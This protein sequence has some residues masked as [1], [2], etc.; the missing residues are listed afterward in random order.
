MKRLIP[1]LFAA[2]ALGISLM[3][4]TQ[5]ATDRLDQPLS[6]A[7]S[8]STESLDNGL[9]EQLR[10]ARMQGSTSAIDKLIESIQQ[11][12][13]ASPQQKSLWHSL[14][15]SYLERALQRAHLRGMAPGQPTFSTL[16]NDFRKDLTLGLE[17]VEKAREYGDES[18]ELFRIEAALMSQH[19]TGVTTAIRW[20]RKITASLTQASNRIYGDPKL[21]VALGLRKLLA[22]TWFGNDPEKALEHFKIADKAEDDERPAIFAAMAS[23]LKEDTQQATRW[24][25]RALQINPQNK[26][27]RVVLKRL[28]KNEGEPFSRDVSE[29]EL[30]ALH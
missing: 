2:L 23:F 5:L 18:G 16:P 3:I 26:F 14:A 1:V 11:A 9:S 22:P 15:E 6:K 17:A 20:N 28:E 29:E 27:A 7:A 4:W 19:I 21:H 8:K 13:A 24:L 30:A 12:I 10:I 25:Q